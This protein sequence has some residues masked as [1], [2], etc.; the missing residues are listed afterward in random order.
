MRN[1]LF[2]PPGLISAL[3]S[4]FEFRALYLALQVY[5]QLCILYIS[6]CP[7]D[8][9]LEKEDRI[10]E[11]KNIKKNSPPTPH[12]LR[13]NNV[14]YRSEYIQETLNYLYTYTVAFSQNF[15]LAR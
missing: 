6:E 11:M 10:D 1:S 5:M 15:E 4:T 12:L 8:E 2:G 7:A 13:N 14:N 3:Y 9:T